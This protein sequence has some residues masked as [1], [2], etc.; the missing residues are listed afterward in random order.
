MPHARCVAQQR[1]AHL[2][3]LSPD[4]VISRQVTKAWLQVQVQAQAQVAVQLAVQLAVYAAVQG[5]Q[6]D[7]SLAIR[8]S[9]NQTTTQPSHQPS[10]PLNTATNPASQS[11]P[12]P[13]Q[14]ASQP[15]APAHVSEA[16][17]RTS[18][19][20]IFIRE[21]PR[22]AFQPSI[23][24]VRPAMHAQSGWMHCTCSPLPHTSDILARLPLC[25]VG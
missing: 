15:A 11:P 8:L 16:N 12:S 25:K 4:S 21:E 24:A 7:N 23:T 18:S 20:S 3:R 22:I 1:L 6:A 17:I 9:V 19:I 2:P 14:P 13:T 10:Q 5:H